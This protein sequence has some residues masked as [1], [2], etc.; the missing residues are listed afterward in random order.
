MPLLLPVDLILYNDNVTN[1]MAWPD[2]TGVT[3]VA[4]QPLVDPDHGK[5]VFVYDPFTNS[6]FWAGRGGQLISHFYKELELADYR[7]LWAE[8]N[9]GGN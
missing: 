9:F 8:V 4:P 2:M 6:T 3:R 1:H 7:T 5:F